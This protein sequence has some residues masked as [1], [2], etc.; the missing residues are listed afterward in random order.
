MEWKGGSV[1]GEGLYRVDGGGYDPG[2]AWARWGTRKIPRMRI[3]WRT[4]G[5]IALL[6]PAQVVGIAGLVAGLPVALAPQRIEADTAAG[7][8]SST[9]SVGPA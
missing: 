3:E 9:R 1:L 6:V 2:C 8:G 4:A 5:V 7:R